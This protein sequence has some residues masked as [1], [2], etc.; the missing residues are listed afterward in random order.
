MKSISILGCGWLGLP[1][2]K[3]L[4]SNGYRVKGSTTSPDKLSTLAL[5][6]IEPYLIQLKE[7]QTEGDWNGFLA[8][9]TLLVN[10]P[11]GL[12]G[13]SSENFVL[14]I[15][16]LLKKL[17]GTQVKWLIFVSSTS[18]FGELQGCVDETSLPLPDTEAGR[19]LLACEN[20]V[21][22]QNALKTTVI[23]L[24][25]LIGENRHPVKFL[26]GRKNLPDGDAYINF[27]HQSDAIG[28]IGHVLNQQLTG[29]VH[30]VAPHHPKKKDYYLSEAKKL[31]IAPPEYASGSGDKN[32]KK[33]LSTINYPYRFAFN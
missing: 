2:A 8:S 6:H 22:Q 1:L 20:L 10:I 21:L 30:G 12:R 15:E 17:H 14:K 13:G 31:G 3:V 18:V 7:R 25:G 11:P 29:I 24:G 23:R 26:S 28:L 9:E 32:Y 16:S 5:Y 4:V 33:V 27:I 19:Q